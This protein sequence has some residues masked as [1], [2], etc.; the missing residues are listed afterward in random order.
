[1]ATQLQKELYG[2]HIDSIKKGA[3]L[4]LLSQKPQIPN[5]KYFREKLTLSAKADSSRLK[6]G[7]GYYEMVST[8][9]YDL[10]EA[11][12][13]LDF[14]EQLTLTEDFAQADKDVLVQNALLEM[15]KVV[16][17]LVKKVVEKVS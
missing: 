2:V 6:E 12:A 3:I 17:K 15:A 9:E 14:C 16:K 13:V 7:F 8:T 1:M 5:S 4:K 11:N 10:L